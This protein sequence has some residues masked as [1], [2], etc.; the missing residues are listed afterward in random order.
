MNA[1]RFYRALLRSFSILSVI[2][3]VE[4]GAA[5]SFKGIDMSALNPTAFYSISL[6]CQ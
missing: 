4:K 5:F 2:R 1:F 3:P 6:T